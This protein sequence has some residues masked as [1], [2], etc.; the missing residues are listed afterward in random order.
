[1][2]CSSSKSAP[3]T[4]APT[5]SGKD[6]NDPTKYGPYD[7]GDKSKTLTLAAKI[8][9]NDKARGWFEHGLAW[10][11]GYNHEEAI[12]CY[13]KALEA[14]PNCA[15]ALWGIAYSLSSSYN[16]SPGLGCGY[17]HIQNA[18]K[19]KDKV[20]PLE[21][22]MIEALATR[23]SEEAKN[24]ADPTKLNFGNP[25]ELNIAFAEAMANVAAKY[26]DDLDVA[27]VYCEGLMNIKPWALWDRK[28]D[29]KGGYTITAA[30]DNTLKAK[31][32]LEKTLA[33]PDGA[34]HPALCH[35]YC[36]LMELSPE[37]AAALPQANT[38]RTLMPAMGHLVHMPSH[39]D[40]WVGGYEQG[41]SCNEAGTAADDKYVELSGNESQFYKFYRMHNM[42]F[43]V[44]M[45][46]HDG[47]YENA[48]KYAR[49]MQTQL[50]KEH[51]TFMLGGVI[52][53]GAV[54]LEAFN[55]MPWHV[56]IRFGKWD[57]II[58]EPIPDDVEAFAGSV[59]TAHYARGIAFA[60]KGMVTK[61]EEA[62]DEFKKSL[63][64]P[65]LAG[66]L[67]HNNPMYAA[68]GPCVL[69]VA[70]AMLAGEIAYRKAV[71]N[72]ADDTAFDAA[73]D[74]I[75][76]A[77]DLSES[78]KYD[79]PWGWMVPARHALGALLLEQKR[80]PEA[81]ETYG[82]DVALWKDNMWGLFGMIQTIESMPNEAEDRSKLPELKAKF[83]EASKRADVKL[84]ATCFCA[85]AA[86]AASEK[87]C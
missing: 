34:L 50:Q 64:N 11:Y 48:M 19:L 72:G 81:L 37:P 5:K 2:G 1:M 85:Q 31:E 66:R 58:A 44:W 76:K 47:R 74:L 18:L 84:T 79:E 52:P 69:N 10:M 87:C 6:I 33:T 27:A 78:L 71:V 59:A 49:K 80:I 73:F 54:F 13:T 63:Q 12:A 29:G 65:A 4:E 60:S 83:E 38:L 40:A 25:P 30:D 42:H 75:R 23:S 17:D 21:Q 28:R 46:M 14:D 15:M 8:T 41:V 67:L 86:G 3:P 53:M 82:E 45:S 56:M 68:E 7:Y 22:D 70:E 62:Q 9:A 32:V 39:I 55:T 57:D 61:A 36:H 24:A 35:L 16:W 26:P 20:S 43:T 77:V 51:V